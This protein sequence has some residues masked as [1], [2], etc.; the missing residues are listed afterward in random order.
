MKNQKQ[1]VEKFNQLIEIGF[2]MRQISRASGIPVSN[3]HRLMIEDESTFKARE[4][5]L[6]KAN[7]GINKI[8]K[9]IKSCLEDEEN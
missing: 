4:I 9:D 3:I 1:V 5:T 6:T 7:I 2:S 8:I